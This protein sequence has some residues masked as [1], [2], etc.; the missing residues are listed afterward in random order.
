MGGGGDFFLFLFFCLVFLPAPAKDSNKLI[1][2]ELDSSHEAISDEN[3]MPTSD[4]VEN[5]RGLCAAVDN[6][7]V[8]ARPQ[9]QIAGVQ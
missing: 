8:F 1:A 7:F 6:K 4:V 3:S 2:G 9:E 5:Y